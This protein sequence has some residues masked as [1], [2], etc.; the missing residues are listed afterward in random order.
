MSDPSCCFTLIIHPYINKRH[1][2]V[3]RAYDDLVPQWDEAGRMRL[4]IEVRY[5]GEVIFPKGRL[6]RP[7]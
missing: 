3:I 6:L 7:P 1:R 2:I 5:A 4:T